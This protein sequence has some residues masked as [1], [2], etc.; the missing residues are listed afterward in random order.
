MPVVTIS[1]ELGSEGTRIAEEVARA[2]GAECVDKEVLAEM[3][4]QAGLPVEAIAQAEEKLLSRPTLVSRDMQA[5]FSKG[6]QARGTSLTEAS[7]VAQMSE[8]IRALAE[9]GNIVFVG[10]GAQLI[11]Q[12]HPSA[13]HVHLHAPLDVRARRLQARRGLADLEAARRVIQQAD[14]QRRGWFRRFFAGAD[15]KNPRYYHL[16]IDTWRVPP[17]LAIAIIVQAARAAPTL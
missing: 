9:R 4:R 2:L 7:Y 11:L 17:E 8:A 6:Q 3:A 1:R 15:W 14:E 10:R 16:M 13:L 5:L 12:E